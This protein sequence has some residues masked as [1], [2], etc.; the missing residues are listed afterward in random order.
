MRRVRSTFLSRRDFLIH[1]TAWTA[2]PFVPASAFA[3]SAYP[4]R[5]IPNTG[6]PLPVVGL[7][8]TKAVSQLAERGTAEFKALLRTLLDGGG[9]VVDTW[10]RTPALD[11]MTGEALQAEGLVG[12]LFLATKVDAVGAEAGRAMLERTRRLFGK[13]SD[14]IQV[15]S[16]RDLKTQWS[17]L[18]EWK[19]AGKAR[20]I[21]ATVSSDPHHEA[22]IDFM[23]GERPDFIQVNY[24][25]VETHAERGVLPLAADLGIAV[26]INR[27]FMNGSYFSRVQ[28]VALPEWAAK[29]DCHSWAQFSLKYILAHPAVTCVLTETTNPRHLLENLSTA[30]GRFP[31]EETQRRM[32]EVVQFI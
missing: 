11:E 26:L 29:F 20:Y 8:S 19:D 27:P 16:L 6:E 30:Y 23:R 2:L 1:A 7:G 10:S 14:L 21:G 5:P 25:V 31:D 12:D 18:K 17:V 13:T 24:S 15:I 22:M 9:T 32:R 28:G 3:Q 4:T